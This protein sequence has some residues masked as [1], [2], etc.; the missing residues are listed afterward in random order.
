MNKLIQS[1]L[2]VLAISGAT[3]YHLIELDH[4]VNAAEQ[5]QQ[6]VN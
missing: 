3:A 6:E 4:G 2:I 1:L 5:L